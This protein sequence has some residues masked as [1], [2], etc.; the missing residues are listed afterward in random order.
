MQNI[1]KPGRRGRRNETHSGFTGWEQIKNSKAVSTPHLLRSSEQETDFVGPSR[2]IH[3]V[4]K[5]SEVKQNTRIYR[6][7]YF[8]IMYNLQSILILKYSDSHKRSFIC[9]NRAGK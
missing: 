7:E 9:D 8:V 5:D 3:S 6:I 4:Q 1:A 2:V